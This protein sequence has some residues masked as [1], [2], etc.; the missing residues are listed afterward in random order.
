MFVKQKFENMFITRFK[1]IVKKTVTVVASREFAFIYCLLGTFGEVAHCYYLLNSVSSFSGF[2]RHFQAAV[3]SLFISS[4]LMY[5]VSISDSSDE[6]Q[7][8]KRIKRA[9]N[10]FMTMEIL[11][12]MYYYCQHLIIKAETMRI[13]DFIFGTIISCLIPVTIKLYSNS[14][15]AKQWIQEIESRETPTNETAN[16]PKEI[17]TYGLDEKEIIEMVNKKIGELEI[18][19]EDD[20]KN[21]ID[22][23]LDERLKTLKEENNNDEG[24]SVDDLLFESKVKAMVEKN[25][26]EILR[27]NPELKTKESLKNLVIDE[28]EKIKKLNKEYIDE[29]IAEK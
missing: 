11:M 6:E 13:F 3:L 14:I 24:Y 26:N 22:S 17:S 12:N 8:Q 25:V 1:D 7:E 19:S 2:F 15:K 20:V 5:F 21:F 27:Q 18:L 10:L 9:V 28:F 16:Q 4:S 23:S 29:K